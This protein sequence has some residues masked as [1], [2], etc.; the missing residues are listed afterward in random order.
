MEY[1]A[2]SDS[3]LLISDISCS[4]QIKADCP[5]FFKMRQLIGER[6]NL[7]PVGLGDSGTDIDLSVLAADGPASSE[8][9][10]LVGTVLDDD[11]VNPSSDSEFPLDVDDT[12]TSSADHDVND[13]S[14]PASNS[15]QSPPPATEQRKKRKAAS[16][17]PSKPAATTT[18]PKRPAKKSKLDEFASAVTAE[19]HARNKEL[20][21]RR[22]SVESKAKVLVAREHTKT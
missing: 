16:P 14:Y 4:E 12:A 21:V 8:A 17:S 19:A 9:D 20:D 18:A 5:W 10:R 3:S 13:S 1:V 11:V 15:H 6:P 22:V 2:F 7:V